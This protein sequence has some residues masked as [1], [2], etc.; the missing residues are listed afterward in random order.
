VYAILI[1]EDAAD[2]GTTQGEYLDRHLERLTT[3]RAAN[4]TVSIDPRTARHFQDAAGE[5]G[6]GQLSH[7][8]QAMDTSTNQG[9]RL[10]YPSVHVFPPHELS[11]LKKPTRE[12]HLDDRRELLNE[13]FL[14]QPSLRAVP[15][16]LIV[17]LALLPGEGHAMEV[18][19]AMEEVGAAHRDPIADPRG[20]LREVTG[21]KLL[22]AFGRRMPVIVTTS[23]RNPLV[24]QHCLVNGAFAVIVKPV[25]ASSDGF[26]F[27][28]ALNRQFDVLEL[29]ARRN[30][31]TLDVVVAHYLT[32]AACEVLKAMAALTCGLPDDDE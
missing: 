25:A 1:I 15:D 31:S 27:K 21:F 12:P 29:S 26:D 10:S 4:A 2:L 24:A 32:Q 28:T 22:E 6:Q 5:P 13:I 8:R 17:D 3:T 9:E 7:L 11:R 14:D 20:A 30:A 18:A 19:G 16:I 23:A